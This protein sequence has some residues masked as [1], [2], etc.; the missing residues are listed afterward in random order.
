MEEPEGFSRVKL[1]TELGN[2]HIPGFILLPKNEGN[3]ETQYLDKVHFYYVNNDPINSGDW[4]II[5]DTLQ[6]C[7]STKPYIVES[8]ETYQN[9][10]D[11]EE[12]RKFPNHFCRKVIMSTNP[13]PIIHGV[14]E[15]PE[16]LIR[17][18]IIIYNKFLITEVNE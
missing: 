17:E 13:I 2:P 12:Y 15:I 7:K 16:K 1:N 8:Y 10:N 9:L 4:F 3:I 6:R 11:I 5:K 14:K 18:Y